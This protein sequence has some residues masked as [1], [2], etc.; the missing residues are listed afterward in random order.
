MVFIMSHEILVV[1]DDYK[2]HHFMT[3]YLY[4][5]SVLFRNISMDFD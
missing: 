3:L 2:K 5:K 4:E 1:S